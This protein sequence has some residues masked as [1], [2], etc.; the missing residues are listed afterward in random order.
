MVLA[1]KKNQPQA[2]LGNSLFSLRLHRRDA[3]ATFLECYS[4]LIPVQLMQGS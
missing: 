1:M 4:V 2:D 3:C